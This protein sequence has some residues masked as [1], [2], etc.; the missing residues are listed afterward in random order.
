M[1][2]TLC[3][4][5]VNIQ[6]NVLR[7]SSTNSHFDRHV[8]SIDSRVESESCLAHSDCRTENHPRGELDNR[9]VSAATKTIKPQSWK[10]VGMPFTNE[11]TRMSRSRPITMKFS[12]KIAN[13]M[14][15]NIYSAQVVSTF[16]RYFAERLT[17]LKGCRMFLVRATNLSQRYIKIQPFLNK[18]AKFRLD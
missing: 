8:A 6:R 3:F 17:T 10:P 14:K 12:G 15:F 18:C 4:N 16:G 2:L 7:V 5:V 13:R 11:A 1:K 9:S